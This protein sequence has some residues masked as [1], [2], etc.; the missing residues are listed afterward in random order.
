MR[1]SFFLK[2][3]NGKALGITTGAFYFCFDD[4]KRQEDRLLPGKV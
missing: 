4:V 2:T 3:L 1:Q